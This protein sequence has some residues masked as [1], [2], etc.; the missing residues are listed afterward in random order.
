M[1][2]AAILVQVEADP[3]CRPRIV[4]AAELTRRFGAA[5]V[6]V[7]AR[8]LTPPVAPG[9]AGPVL[10]AAVLDRQQEEIEADLAEAERE[11]R[12]ATDGCGQP[13]TWHASLGDPAEMVALHGRAADL[14]V[15]GRRPETSPAQVTR[16]ADPGDVLMQAG[17]P[18]LVVPPGI[19]RL[20]A[21]NVV[22]AWKDTREA[23]RA[24]LDALPF[25]QQAAGV[26]VLA[27]CERDEDLGAARTGAQEVAAH[28]SRHG[29]KAATPDARPVRE[30][31]VAAELLLA[32]EQ[33]DA[34]LIVAGAYGHTRLR[35]WAFGGVTRS[36]IRHGTKCCLLSH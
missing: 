25:L 20:E 8:D 32:A 31:S 21:R 7:A 30:A 33:R 29:V 13:V 1:T 34:D 10:V 12:A 24:V 36:L 35:E 16:R 11:F 6:G 18:V 4:L 26:L 22:V 28:L 9:T 14:L 19:S 17:R 23:R 15:V 27:V 3:D 2:Y 5:L